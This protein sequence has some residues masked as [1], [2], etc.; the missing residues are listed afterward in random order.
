MGATVGPLND[1]VKELPEIS[2]KAVYA[3]TKFSMD[4]PDITDKW[5]KSAGDIRHVVIFGIE[6]HVCVLQTTL[7]LLDRGIQVHVIKDG[8]SSCNPGEIDVALE[9]SLVKCFANASVDVCF[10]ILYTDQLLLSP[11]LWQ[12]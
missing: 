4:L 9:V 3:K 12:P 10:G 8:V 5:L 1:L 6:S 2:S 11:P 7:D